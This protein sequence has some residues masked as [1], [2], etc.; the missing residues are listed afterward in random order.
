M[1][2]RGDLVAFQFFQV[3]SRGAGGK[4]LDAPRLVLFKFSHDTKF[5]ATGNKLPCLPIPI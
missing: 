1:G 3:N 5:L 2:E 4:I